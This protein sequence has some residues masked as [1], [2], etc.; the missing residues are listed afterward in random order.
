RDPQGLEEGRQ[1]G[2]DA[3]ED[4]AVGGAAPLLR[5]DL[6]PLGENLVGRGQA[7][8]PENVRM[9]AHDLVTDGTHDAIEVEVTALLGDARLEHDLKKEIP[10][11][12]ADPTRRARRDGLNDL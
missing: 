8:V 9:T 7:S 6:L 5:F 3:R 11:L 4:G 10:Q 1:R 12:L 2:G